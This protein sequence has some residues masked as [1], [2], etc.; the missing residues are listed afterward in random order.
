MTDVPKR[1]R[2]RPPRE[3]FTDP[4]GAHDIGVEAAGPTA[5]RRRKA[6]GG[7]HLKLAA[8]PREGF[9]RRWFTDKPGRLAEAEELAYTHVCDSSIKSDGT[10]SRVRRLTGTDGHGAP[11]YS[12]LMETPLEEYQAGIDDK[13]E[14]HANFEASIQRGQDPSGQLTDAYGRGEISTSNRG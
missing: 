2:G 14:A 7:V 9:F 5:R 11:Q 1:R 12:Y 4:Q 8:P 3:S 13:E 10:D 6:V